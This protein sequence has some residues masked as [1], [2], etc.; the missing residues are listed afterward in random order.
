MDIDKPLI[1]PLSFVDDI[2]CSFSLHLEFYGI[3]I[4]L[5]KKAI[6]SLTKQGKAELI[7]GTSLDD[8]DTGVKFFS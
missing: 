3:E 1:M 2:Y 7:V 6:Q 5:L 4:W 8:S